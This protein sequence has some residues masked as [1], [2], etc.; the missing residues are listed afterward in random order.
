MCLSNVCN[1]CE[2]A[3]LLFRPGKGECKT[4]HWYSPTNDDN[5]WE[6]KKKKWISSLFCFAR[7]LFHCIISKILSLTDF[8]KSTHWVAKIF[9]YGFKRTKNQAVTKYEL[10]LPACICTNIIHQ[11]EILQS[12]FYFAKRNIFSC[13]QFYKILFAIYRGRK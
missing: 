2:R 7:E 5:K 13:L 4:H 9:A 8:K 6:T 1:C 10:L 12:C 11:W 3:Q